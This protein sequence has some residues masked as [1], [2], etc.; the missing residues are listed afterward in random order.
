MR[1]VIN[2]RKKEQNVTMF[3]CSFFCIHK[4]AG[5]FPIKHSG[6]V[7]ILAVLLICSSFCLSSCNKDNDSNLKQQQLT[8]KDI[9]KAHNECLAFILNGISRESQRVKAFGA[10]DTLSKKE[11]QEIATDDTQV[12]IKRYNLSDSIQQRVYNY[13]DSLVL[14][15]GFADTLNCAN[16]NMS[17]M[18][19]SFCT[20][21]DSIFNDSDTDLSSLESRLSI[22]KNRAQQ[23][24][25]GEELKTVLSGCSVAEYTLQYWY[26]NLNTWEAM[27]PTNGTKAKINS[28]LSWKALGKADVTGAIHGALHTYGAFLLGTGPVGWQIAAAI[29]VAGAVGSSAGNAIDQLW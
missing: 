28:K 6:F 11:V 8:T 1:N 12:Y 4:T 18:V 7:N 15:G 13:M 14:G 3:F 27:A 25:Q 16:V 26:T 22:V 2:L 20:Q 19:A 23:E 24:L 17:P 29:V 5:S 9:G 21:L 10:V